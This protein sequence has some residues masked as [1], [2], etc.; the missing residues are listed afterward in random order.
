MKTNASNYT[1]AAVL[2]QR[3]KPLT[4]MSKKMNAA[5]QNYT[6]TE[7]EMMAIIQGIYQWCKYLEGAREPTKVITDYKNLEYFKLAK[8]TNRRQA[9]WALE[10][11]DVP[12]YIEYRTEKENIVVDVLS[13]RKDNTEPLPDRTILN[14]NMTW[15][16]AKEKGYHPEIDVGFLEKRGND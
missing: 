5:E 6:I 15:E 8:I 9:R 7:K 11:Q 16:K 13:R 2:T 4:F 12:Y 1:T 14:R 10:I 3:R